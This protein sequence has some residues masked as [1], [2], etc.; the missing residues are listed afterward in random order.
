MPGSKSGQISTKSGSRRS[1]LQRRSGMHGGG[2]KQLGA[3]TGG[4]REK[5]SKVGG[6]LS[7]PP[8]VPPLHLH[9]EAPAAAPLHGAEKTPEEDKVA[10]RDAS[11]TPASFMPQRWITVALGRPVVVLRGYANPLCQFTAH[12]CIG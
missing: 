11:M 10:L 5:Q 4:R 6:T 7:L 2:A 9:E 3:P 12:T 8:S 1:G